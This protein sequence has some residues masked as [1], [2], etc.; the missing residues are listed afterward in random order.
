MRGR[1][2]FRRECSGHASDGFC[3]LLEQTLVFITHPRQ[4]SNFKAAGE[5]AA[6]GG[7]PGSQ[8]T[9]SDE[10]SI[11]STMRVLR[12]LSLAAL[13]VP[14]ACA[15]ETLA[16]R[17]DLHSMVNDYLTSIARQYWTKRSETIAAIRTPQQ[18][19]ERQQYIRSTFIKL[20]GGFPEK[21]PLNPRITG[22]LLRDGYRIDHLIYESRPKFFVTANLYVPTTGRAPYPA[23]LGVA[24]HS[25]ASKA[26]ALYQH[27]WIALVKRGYIVLAFDPPGQGERTFY[28]DAELGRSRVGSATTEHT[29]AGLQCFLTGSSLAQYFTWDGIRSLD[30]LL[31]RGDVDPQRIAIAGNS[32]GGTQAAYLAA[33][34][35]RLAA[36]APSCY[37]TSSETLWFD[38]GPQ[39]A[40]QNVAGF[41]SSGLNV[42]DFPLAFAPRPLEFLTA[43]R[44]FFPIKGAHDAFA[45]AER[46]YQILDVPDHVKFFEYDDTHGW[47]LPRREET[48]RWFQRWLNHQPEDRGKEPEFQTEPEGLLNATKTGQLA[49]SLGGETVPSL[50][51]AL[52]RQLASRRPH[53]DPQQLL[54]RIVS[55]LGIQPER[56]HTPPP[57]ASA[58]TLAR[59]EYR[60]DKLILETEPGIHIPALLFVPKGGAAARKPAVMYLNSGGKATDARPGGDL[61]ALVQTGN[62]VLAPD[63]R[64]VGETESRQGSN[65]YNGRYQTALRALLVGKN[66][67]GMQTL[68]LL[69]S[70]DY[71]IARDDV[72]PARITVIGK[73]NALVPAI[74]AAALEPRITKLA[75][76]GGPVSFLDL[77]ALRFHGDIANVIV[78]GVL[79]DFDLPDVLALIAPRPVWIVDP[80]MPSGAP[81]QLSKVE[82]E[83]QVVRKKFQDAKANGNFRILAR[84]EGWSFDYFYKDWLARE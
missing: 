36:A 34:E 79:E 65:P 56:D 46:F 78:P 50:N 45:E 38:P 83:Y 39:D 26:Y 40:E 32:G 3:G 7:R 29:D 19:R 73:G 31:S 42:K 60:I 20:M 41:L 12:I 48:Y 9:F 17:G 18:V 68:D 76:A 27:A 10:D 4:L 24:G 25:D 14:G 8:R 54:A 64:G 61:E 51:A 75:C 66:M 13:L 62:I 80:R 84:P 15:Q 5:N 30:Y 81:E 70:L 2:E 58:G 53:L 16:V 43:T 69:R 23:V 71:L 37:L 44:D 33:A 77:A 72:D 63:L 11:L 52:A 28:Y 22:S 55:R 59:P 35:S 74:F 6:T 57:V 47:S 1:C 82:T 49:T 21:T 67:P